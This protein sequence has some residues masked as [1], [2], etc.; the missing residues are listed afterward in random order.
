LAKNLVIVESP[1][2]ARTIERY[3]GRDFVVK[4]SKG[5]VKDLPTS[6]LGVDV[7]AG[8]VPEYVTVRGKGTVLK[9]IRKASESAET[10]FLAPDPDR[11]GEAIAWHIADEI[12]RGKKNGAP[13]IKRVLI[14]E[15]TRRGVNEAFEHPRDL[16]ED[17][18]NSQQARRVLDRLVGYQ[19]SPLLWDKVRRGLLVG[20]V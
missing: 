5:H 16:D 19:L 4:A 13:H 8:F 9:D 11:E 14:T 20:R 2:K 7:A 10:V 12:T 18:Y 1:A 6:E 3:L 15:I 17:L